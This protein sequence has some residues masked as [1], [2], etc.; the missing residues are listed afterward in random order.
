M[1]CEVI[2]CGKIVPTLLLVQNLDCQMSFFN[3]T[4]VHNV[5]AILCENNELNPINR[6]WWK[7]SMS[8]ILTHKLSK[9]MRLVEIVI[10]QVLSFVEN[11]HTFNIVS[12]MN[13]KLWIRLNIHL[14]LCTKFIMNNFFPFRIFL[15]NR[16]LPRARKGLLLCGCIGE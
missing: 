7:F 12:F 10:V 5:K 11:K 16:P 1:L 13:N 2:D 9:Y 15:M 4:M 6:L 8:A 14:D 3:M